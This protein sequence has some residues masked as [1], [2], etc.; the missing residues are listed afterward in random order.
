MCLIIAF[1]AIVYAIS[2]FNAGDAA[3]GSSAVAVALFFIGL[4][5]KNIIDVKNMRNNKNKEES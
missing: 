2:A 4:L 5:I 1:I 3:L